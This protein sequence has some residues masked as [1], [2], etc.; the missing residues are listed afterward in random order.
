MRQSTLFW[1]SRLIERSC[2][3]GAIEKHS[4]DKIERKISAQYF[5]SVIDTPSLSRKLHYR[6]HGFLPGENRGGNCPFVLVFLA[7][8]GEWLGRWNLGSK[9]ALINLV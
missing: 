6:C 2:T 7:P 3:L 1:I 5:A 9:L 8:L 4:K